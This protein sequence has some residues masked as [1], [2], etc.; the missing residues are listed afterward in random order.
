MHS[1][2]SYLSEPNT[3]SR[4]SG[5]YLL[6]WVPC[7]SEPIRINGAVLTL[8]NILRCVTSSAAKA[9]LG[10]LFMNC[11]EERILR[12]ILNEMGHN[13]PPTPVHCNNSTAVSIANDTVKRQRSRSMEMRYFWVVDQCQ[14]KHFNVVGCPGKEILAD[15]QSKHHVG[16]HHQNVRPWYL[17]ENNSPRVLPQLWRLGPCEGVGKTPGDNPDVPHYR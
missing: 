12:L 9:E 10:A 2:A 3:R 4:A 6:V 15:Y 17:H 8:C 11:K 13:Q 16:T 7:R 14:Q 1:D 5:N